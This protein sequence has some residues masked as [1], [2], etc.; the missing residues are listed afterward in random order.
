MQKGKPEVDAAA[1]FFE[2]VMDFRDPRDAIREAISNDFDAG[3]TEI[4][5]RARIVPYRGQDE[6]VLTFEDNG[7]GIEAESLDAGVP[8]LH[9]FFDLGRSTSRESPDRIGQKGH[10]TKTFFNSRE[11]EVYSWRNGQETYAVMPEPR[12][13]LAEKQIPEYDWEHR[14]CADPLKTG[15]TIVVKGYNQ[16]RTQ[17]FSHDELMDF[18]YWFTKF[19]SI[20]AELGL[21]THAT[22]KLTLQGL[23]RETPEV[24]EFG[25]R[26]PAKEQYDLKSLRREDA[27]SPTKYF[28]KK[29]CES[30]IPIKGFPHYSLDMVFYIEGDRAKSYNKMIRR[31][32][33]PVREG[34]YLVEQRYGLW[35]AKDYIPVQN[36]TEW[37]GRG[38]RA[39]S[40]KFHAF[41][42][43]QQFKLT[44]NRGDVGN[45]DERLMSA[46]RETIVTWFQNIVLGDP[47]YQKY[48]EELA[49][50]V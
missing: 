41:A 39:A 45:T 49:L 43:C 31:Q 11:I 48:E 37:I 12:S 8:N 13:R 44:A 35:A 46:I 20:E 42:N 21:L 36:L 1:E 38:Q 4:S 7:V 5:V 27:G 10:G 23:G 34:M 24:L 40:T 19:G 22:T 3:A 17:G 30:G 47:V 32:G 25:H 2:I 50:E 15:T 29:W 28:V 16:N 33:A 6:L 9:A 14:P 26:F 18:I